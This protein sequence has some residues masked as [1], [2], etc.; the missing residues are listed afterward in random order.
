MFSQK[1]NKAMELTTKISDFKLILYV[2]NKIFHER[3]YFITTKHVIIVKSC[4]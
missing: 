3:L 2:F 1:K 4:L